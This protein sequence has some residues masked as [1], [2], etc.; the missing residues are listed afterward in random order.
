[1]LDVGEHGVVD[2]AEAGG[3]DPLAV[4]ILHRLVLLLADD[5]R[6]A[7]R[8]RHD[9]AQIAAAR[10]ELHEWH[11]GRHDGVEIVDIEQRGRTVGIGLA[12]DLDAF[13]LVVAVEFG[14]PHR[15]VVHFRSVLVCEAHGLEGLG[16]SRPG[17]LQR[18]RGGQKRGCA[19]GLQ[20]FASGLHRFLLACLVVCRR[21]VRSLA[22]SRLVLPAALPP[23]RPERHAASVRTASEFL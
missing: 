7:L 20:C 8:H 1:M 16:E 3:A 19:H 10:H 11:D 13:L 23:P 18:R 12:L 22:S 17:S 2:G 21:V 4:E 14:H 15:G 9:D 5:R 6:V